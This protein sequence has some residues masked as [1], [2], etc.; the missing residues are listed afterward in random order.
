MVST[1]RTMHSA[2]GDEIGDGCHSRWING[3]QDASTA[4]GNIVEDG[5]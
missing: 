1:F 3:H 2:A 4:S 5:K